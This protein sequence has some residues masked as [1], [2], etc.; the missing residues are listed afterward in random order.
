MG[1]FYFLPKKSKNLLINKKNRIIMAKKDNELIY[2]LSENSRMSLKE[3]S[4]HLKKSS[5]RLKYSISTLEKEGIIR[6]PYCV[7]DYSY[8]GLLLFRVYFKGGYIDEGDK[9]NILKRLNSNPYII[10]TYELTGEFDLVAEF[11]CPNPSKFNKELKKIVQIF[12]TLNDYKIILNLVTYLYPRNFLISNKELEASN[13]EKIVGGDRDVA[14]ISKNEIGVLKNILPEPKIRLTKLAKRSGLNIKTVKTILSN[15]QEKNII[16]GYK[17]ILD[18]NKLGLNKCRLFLKLHNISQ[19]REKELNEY[20][21]KIQEIVQVN[22][23]VGDWDLEIDIE[24]AGSSRTRYII[25][26]I[27]KEFRDLIESFNLIEF[28]TYYK[29]SYLPMYLFEIDKKEKE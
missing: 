22:K 29:R 18:T 17:Y 24:A 12:P 10:T 28:F 19:D 11:L 7:F 9:V 23:T 13:I 8:F 3:L 26:L 15:L 4:Y 6:E 27:R 25:M 16:R 5:Q 20:M 1:V 2:M 21:Q 14:E